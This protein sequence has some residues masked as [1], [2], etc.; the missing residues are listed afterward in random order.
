MGLDIEKSV[1]E[2]VSLGRKK[3]LWRHGA[4]FKHY[5]RHQLFGGIDFRGR[6]MLDIGAGNGKFSL[7]AA[8][9]GAASIVALEPT[10]DGADAGSKVGSLRSMRDTLGFANIEIE[11]SRIQDHIPKMLYDIVLLHYSVNHLDEYACVTLRQDPGS[12]AAYQEIFRRIYGM[13]A[14]GGFIVMSDCTDTCFWNKVGLTNPFAPDIEWFKHQPPAVWQ[15]LLMSVGFHS[16]ATLWTYEPKSM[17][18]GRLFLSN[19]LVS[20]FYTSIFVLRMT[21]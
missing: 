7:W 19:R 17:D 18:F 15:G 8:A 11:E 20:Y 12:Y 2:Y 4:G 21:R 14:P 16:A 5:C 6:R 10:A 1:A 3:G 9:H 13:M